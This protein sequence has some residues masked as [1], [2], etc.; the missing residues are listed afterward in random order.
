MGRHTLRIIPLLALVAGAASAQNSALQA[1][2]SVEQVFQAIR[3]NDMSSLRQL[4]S[5]GA[6]NVK[7]KLSMSALH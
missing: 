6:A 1:P 7:D 3:A 5:R 2:A 4:T